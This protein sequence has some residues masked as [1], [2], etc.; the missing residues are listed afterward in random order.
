MPN[1]QF[2]FANI[3]LVWVIIIFFTIKLKFIG[4]EWC[5]WVSLKILFPIY[6]MNNWKRGKSMWAIGMWFQVEKTLGISDIFLQ[7]DTSAFVV[8]HK[9]M[10]S[11]R[12]WEWLQIQSIATTPAVIVSG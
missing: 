11:H 12:T 9:K 2:L 8:T 4:A 3:A 6:V 1:A 7:N 10:G 5:I